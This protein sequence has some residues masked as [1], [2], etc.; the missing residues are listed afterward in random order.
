M[1]TQ[2]IRKARKRVHEKVKIIVSR[3][4]PNF[5]FLS[6]DS[7]REF[8]LDSDWWFTVEQYYQ[9]NVHNTLPIRSKIKQNYTT[10]YQLK[11]MVRGIDALFVENNFPLK[12][13][14]S[15]KYRNLQVHE[16]T[17]FTYLEKATIEKFKQHIYLI[18]PLLSTKKSSFVDKG[19]VFYGKVLE[20]VRNSSKT[21][22]CKYKYAEWLKLDQ[23]QFQQTEL[24]LIVDALPQSST[25]KEV[26]QTLSGMATKKNIKGCMDMLAAIDLSEIY[27]NNRKCIDAIVS[28]IKKK[29]KENRTEISVFI[30]IFL[31]SQMKL[32]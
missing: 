5:G 3:N 8:F 21:L 2:N 15:T 16:P 31:K 19:L 6:R 25:M 30:A 12:R 29:I 18:P 14:V 7:Q 26:I 13:K 17:N 11:R 28:Q 10:P 23:V 4:S 9:F 32:V 20:K 22:N 1:S 24:K 27:N